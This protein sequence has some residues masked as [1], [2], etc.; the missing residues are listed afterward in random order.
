METVVPTEGQFMERLLG[1]GTPH[2][3]CPKNGRWRLAEVFADHEAEA[4]YSFWLLPPGGHLS[5]ED[6]RTIQAFDLEL[7]R[8]NTRRE[9]C[10]GCS[11][12]SED[13]IEVPHLDR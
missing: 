1:P 3:D 8:Y 2:Q 7:V 4:S 9:V 11:R 13:S 10:D 12:I 5:E 6:W